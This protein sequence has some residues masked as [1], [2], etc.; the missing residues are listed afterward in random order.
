MHTSFGL[1]LFAFHH[2]HVP[3]FADT[4]PM[5]L[6]HDQDVSQVTYFK[7]HELQGLYISNPEH[8]TLVQATFP[9]DSPDGTL[10]VGCVVSE[11]VT[12]NT[13]AMVS[14]DGHVEPFTQT[15]YHTKYDSKIPTCPSGFAVYGHFKGPWG[16]VIGKKERFTVGE[17]LSFPVYSAKL[18]GS[19][20]NER[21]MYQWFFLGACVVTLIAAYFTRG[22]PNVLVASLF[23]A[24]ALNRF[25]HAWTLGVFG[26]AAAADGIPALLVLLPRNRVKKWGW[27]LFCL[28][29]AGSTAWLSFNALGVSVA[30][31]LVVAQFFDVTRMLARP[32]A[33]FLFL[34][35]GYVVAPLALLV[36]TLGALAV[37]F[38]GTD[39]N[40]ITGYAVGALEPFLPDGAVKRAAD[41]VHEKDNTPFLTSRRAV[42]SVSMGWDVERK[43]RAFR[44]SLD[45]I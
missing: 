13:T 9:T 26:V 28:G 16:V 34:G 15:T 32:V 36:L 11:H 20:W 12:P 27:V 42:A 7:K 14:K 19:W 18:H 33:C 5:R 41:S 39:T 44:V 10:Y 24:G 38:M 43:G 35:S 31:A 37:T 25:A 8:D 45:T 3:Q 2:G 40:P 29:V 23:I 17:L 22:W 30:V 4:F 6:K 1:L 21:Y